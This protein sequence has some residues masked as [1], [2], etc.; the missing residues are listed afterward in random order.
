M[1]IIPDALGATLPGSDNACIAFME[2]RFAASKSTPP[3]ADARSMT[4][5]FDAVF[6]SV[7]E[8]IPSCCDCVYQ[9]YCGVC[10]VVNY[11]IYQDVIEKEPR[12]YRCRIYSGILDYIFTLLNNNE[13]ETIAILDSWR[14]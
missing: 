7:L 2:S 10:P 1:I 4:S 5:A 11:A 12:S 9:P 8:S 6:A 14:K 3:G 13:T